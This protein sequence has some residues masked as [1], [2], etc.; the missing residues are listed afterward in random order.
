MVQNT[1]HQPHNGVSQIFSQH[2]CQ[3]R[4]GLDYL[5]IVRIRV[6]VSSQDLKGATLK[7][8]VNLLSPPSGI[9]SRANGQLRVNQ[10]A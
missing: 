10:F 8:P 7:E 3:V 1:T 4:G 5:S 2:Q 9:V 6:A